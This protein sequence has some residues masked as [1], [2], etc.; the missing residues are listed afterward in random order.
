MRTT[1]ASEQRE[2]GSRH[3]P[4]VCIQRSP[5]RMFSDA[6]PF[7]QSKN[8]NRVFRAPVDPIALIVPY[9]DTVQ[10][11]LPS[12]RDTDRRR[13]YDAQGETR[14]FWIKETKADLGSG[15]RTTGFNVKVQLPQPEIG[16]E[17]DLLMQEHRGYKDDRQGALTLVHH[18]FDCIPLG[19]RS[20]TEVAQ[21]IFARMIMKNKR[22]KPLARYENTTYFNSDAYLRQNSVD[23]AAYFDKLPKFRI[24]GRDPIAHIE[25]R[26]RGSQTIARRGL[27]TME[28]VLFPDTSALLRQSLYFTNADIRPYVEAEARAQSRYDDARSREAYIR[29]TQLDSAQRV[30]ELLHVEMPVDPTPPL[31][32]YPKLLFR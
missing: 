7:I 16:R 31:L 25:P 19:G 27:D 32:I 11:F 6:L 21:W 12:I 15:L 1:G 8:A 20:T 13:L 29:R 2:G 5:L 22:P 26:L 4:V 30:K 17:L 9:C 10:V 3:A 14:A 24:L 28:S 18:S 23:I